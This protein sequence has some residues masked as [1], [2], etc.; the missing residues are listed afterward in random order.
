MNPFL[1]LGATS[2]SG[3]S[4]DT[5]TPEPY[6]WDNRPSS[7]SKLPD[8]PAADDFIS[9]L[10]P[11]FDTSDNT[12]QLSVN[13]TGGFTIDW[14]DG[15]VTPYS[16]GAP[17]SH[18][19][20]YASAP[21][22][23]TDDGYKTVGVLITPTTPGASF[24]SLSLRSSAGFSGVP[25]PVL[26]LRINMPTSTQIGLG[27]VAT[28]SLL[29][30]IV[31]VGVDPSYNSS[32]ANYRSL[33]H[34]VY[35]EGWGTS[36]TNMFGKFSNCDHLTFVHFPDGSLTAATTIASLFSSCI[37]LKSVEFPAGSLT[38]VTDASNLFDSCTALESVAF[39]SGA[40][41]ALTDASSIFNQCHSIKL[42]D[43]SACDLSHVT[44]LIS[45]FGSCA[46]LTRVKFPTSLA[47]L[48]NAS[49]IFNSCTNLRRIINCVLPASFDLP[50]KAL[51]AAELDEIYTALPTVSSKTLDVTGNPGTAGDTPS[52][53]TAK[54]WS[55]SG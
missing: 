41:A 2:S 38:S 54:G 53:A 19:Y 32:F 55:V 51:G 42:I 20:T 21:G 15:T 7:W 10:F 27:D 17:A 25:T 23:V 39:P 28:P 43:L 8:D 18:S 3:D 31:F 1:F 52:I 16:S 36:V 46:A 13:V 4:G 5:G 33:E 47:A 14:G 9:A 34:V 44:S 24:S 29:R 48:T 40:F 22:A 37:A 45:T 6:P 12:I 49:G 30:R 11:V 35:P 50:N 26:D